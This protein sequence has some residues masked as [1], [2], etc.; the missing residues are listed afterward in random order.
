MVEVIDLK[1]I[2]PNLVYE[3]SFILAIARIKD[4]FSILK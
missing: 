1:V 4:Y 3:H 2:M